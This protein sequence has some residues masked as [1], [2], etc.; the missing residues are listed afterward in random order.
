MQEKQQY[1]DMLI[2]GVRVVSVANE[3]DT[4]TLDPE[5]FENTEFFMKIMKSVDDRFL[6]KNKDINKIAFPV[7]GSLLIKSTDPG[8]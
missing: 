6:M 3:N 1:E 4:L 2:E 5:L 8:F 7:E